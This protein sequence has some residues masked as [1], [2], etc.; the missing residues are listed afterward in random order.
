MVVMDLLLSR[1]KGEQRARA[2]VA[3]QLRDFSRQSGS[4]LEKTHIVA[5]NWVVNDRKES[6]V[7]V[8]A[9]YSRFE[10]T[11]IK[12]VSNPKTAGLDGA[13]SPTGYS[14]SSGLLSDLVRIMA[15]KT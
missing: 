15:E 13:A 14:T 3:F 9:Q 12:I 6:H 5:Q 2:S 1:W 10:R 8:V 4:C 11:I 7:A